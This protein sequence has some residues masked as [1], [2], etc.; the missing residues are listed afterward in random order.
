MTLTQEQLEKQKKIL[1]GEKERLESEIKEL[2]EY[3]DYGNQF[4]DDVQELTDFENML[5]VRERLKIVL[6]KINKALD[7]ISNGTYGKCRVC[8]EYIESARLEAVPYSDTC[9]SCSEKEK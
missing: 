6:K 7:A 1:L 8:K 9:V 5:S 2:A 3:P 4:D